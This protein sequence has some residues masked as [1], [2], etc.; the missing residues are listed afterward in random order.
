M[1]R[2]CV[3]VKKGLEKKKCG[4]KKGV[5]KGVCTLVMK[6]GKKLHGKG[7]RSKG[8]GDGPLGDL[9][10]LLIETGIGIKETISLG[11]EYRKGGDDA[12][13]T[14]LD[15]PGKEPVGGVPGE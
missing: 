3:N 14:P 2:G 5:S 13:G 7:C 10:Y 8:T 4:G 12:G 6:R 15:F 9:V 11:R 1:G